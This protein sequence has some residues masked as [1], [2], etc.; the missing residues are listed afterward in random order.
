[1][2]QDNNTTESNKGKHLT[3]ME[4]KIIEHLYN[5]QDRSYT[6]IGEELGRHRTTIGREIKKG[7]VELLNSDY[8]TREE[9]VAKRGQEFYDR[10]AT[11]KGP[12]IKIAKNHELSE[13]IEK[14]IEE[15][16]SPEVI[17]KKIAEKEEFKITLHFKTIYNYIDKGIL[18]VKREDLTYGSYDTD[19]STQKK[20]KRSTKARKQ[21]RTISDRPQEADERKIG[22]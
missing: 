20:G 17:A 4:R 12:K 21:G 22:H 10:N 9:Y 11:A 8:T 19:N 3:F 16:F 13:F 14:K 5:I 2:C 6:K 18:M 1:M 7:S 15:N